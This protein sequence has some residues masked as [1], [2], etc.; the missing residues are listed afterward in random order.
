MADDKSTLRWI[1]IG[2]FTTLAISLASAVLTYAFLANKA[3]TGTQKVIEPRPELGQL[4]HMGDFLV[5]L[6]D[7]EETHYLRT[8][9]D[10]E[11]NYGSSPE[12]GNEIGNRKAQLRDI[13]ISTLS[14][15]SSEDLRTPEGK[16]ALK[17]ELKERINSVLAKGQIA[18]VYFTEFAIQ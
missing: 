6:A 15:K 2:V 10:L 8:E 18:R 14:S 9:I 16:E 11:Q 3:D 17:E 7:V 5:N 1:L 13:I 12:F 4:E